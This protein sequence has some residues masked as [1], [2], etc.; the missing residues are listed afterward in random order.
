LGARKNV[1]RAFSAAR[2]GYPQIVRVI[3]KKSMKSNIS[4]DF[5]VRALKTLNKKT[6]KKLS[7]VSSTTA[8]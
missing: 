2:S 7:T 3:Q 5:N 4:K 8:A 6:I 1:S